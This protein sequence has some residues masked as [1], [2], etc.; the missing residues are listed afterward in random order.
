MSICPISEPRADAR[1]YYGYIKRSL[2][3]YF[4]MIQ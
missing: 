2:Q 4:I 3:K 1:K